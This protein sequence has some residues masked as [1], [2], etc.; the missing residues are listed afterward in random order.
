MTPP[1]VETSRKIQVNHVAVLGVLYLLV[2]IPGLL[3][4]PGLWVDEGW[5]AEVARQ[6]SR[7]LPL[8][9]PSHSEL[10]RYADRVF[11]MPPLYFVGLGGWF[12]LCGTSIESARL[13][14]VLLGGLAMLLLHALLAR[15]FGARPAFWSTLVWL[16]DTFVWK[17]HR[18]VRFEPAL[19]LAAL[20][21][22]AAGLTAIRREREGRDATWAWLGAGAAVAAMANIHPNAAIL[23][24]SVGTLL[25]VQGG[26]RLLRSRGPWLAI[27]VALLGVVPFGLYLWS[28]RATDF[29]NLLGQNSFHFAEHGHP[30][31]PLWNEAARY[32]SYFPGP[33]RWPAAL[34]WLVTIGWAASRARA[35]RALR[36][37]LAAL[38][39]L[40]L[41]LAL[42]PNKSLLYL[43]AALP[44][45]A[46]LLAGLM[47]RAHPRR[48]RDP[49]GRGAEIVA[50]LLIAANLVVDAALWRRNAG[51][52]PRRLLN[53]VAAELQPG[54]R[55]V[56][57]FVSW[58]AIQD[59]PFREFQRIRNLADIEAFRPTVVI[60]GDRHWE[61]ARSSVF[62]ELAPA[63]EEWLAQSGATPRIFADPVL[64]RL[65]FYRVA[66]PP[67]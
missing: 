16:S 24:L 38:A 52:H 11:W 22:I 66:P 54:D 43:T 47:A 57:T 58:W 30:G 21:A 8:G 4:Y 5:I 28:D 32:A 48:P 18:T 53:A 39:V 33:A 46:A 50:V 41:G 51:T 35:D 23:A 13:F 3:H 42:L 44:V 62:R 20:A 14:S 59:Q 19:T 17:S 26:P 37:P 65:R 56:G 31:L 1:P 2:T 67:D 15:S 27:G 12:S 64:G 34:L 49:L 10:Y 7:G 61:Q 45:G 40:V 25:L 29:A 55:V 60:V 6:F 9:N 63:V 36:A